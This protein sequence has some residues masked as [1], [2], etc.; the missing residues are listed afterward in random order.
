[1]NAGIISTGSDYPEG[2]LTNA[3]LEQIV[4]TSD[5]WITT[6]TGIKERRKA[7][8]DEY[9]SQFA[10]RAGKQAIQR[11]GLKPEDIEIIICATTTPDQILPSTG[12]L[13]QR[14]LGCVNAAGMDVFAAC[15]GFIYGISMVES[16]IRTGQIRYALVIGAEILTKYVDY[17]DRTTC[18]IFGDGAGAAVLGP[19]GEGKGILSTKILS[20]GNFEEQLYARGG[21]T[22]LG[23]THETIDNREH[24]FKMR[25][26]EIFKVAVR[27]MSGISREMLEKAGL[28]VEDVDIVI[29]HQANQRITDAVAK[30]LGVDS[31][32]VYSNIDRMGN[33]SSASIPIAL[34]EVITAGEI[35]EGDVVLL[36]AFGGGITWGA[37]VVRF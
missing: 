2:V 32:K 1:M 12:C 30:K 5:E 9:T 15:S 6:R 36:T 24:F 17:T 28:D 10:V 13:I 3:D 4:E 25:G 29:P 7:A 31:G 11:A 18:V 23:T 20:D 21:G 22:K 35:S 16:M 27:N 8:P 33:T 34:D 19:V 37:S 14:D 26:N